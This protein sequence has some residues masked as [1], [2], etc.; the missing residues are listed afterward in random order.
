MRA[1]GGAKSAR[2]RRVRAV[3]PNN[4]HTPVKF[5]VLLCLEGRSRETERKVR[6]LPLSMP[7]V[8]LVAVHLATHTHT[9]YIYEMAIAG[10]K[11]VA[12]S[13]KACVQCI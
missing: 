6:D 1:K 12:E 13:E 2:E 9:K 3:T 11:A 4:T 7:A 8:E 10:K 5:S